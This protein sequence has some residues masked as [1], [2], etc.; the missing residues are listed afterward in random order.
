M[1]AS[2]YPGAIDPAAPAIEDDCDFVPANALDYAK[3]MI[4]AIQ[5]E[6]GND[7][8]DLTAVGG[9]DFGTVAALL[10]ALCRIEVGTHTTAD[11]KNGMVVTFTAARFT[12]PPLVFLQG[13]SAVE[14]GQ[15]FIF[16][17]K[18]VTKDLFVIGSGHL[19]RATAAGFEVNW[20]AIQPPMGIERS[21]DVDDLN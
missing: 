13:V 20:L 15:R 7:P 5:G 12:S 11:T 3:N 21:P 8:A 17:P 18:R 1:T 19:D 9:L 14:P 10:L 2:D 6:V 4:T 16:S